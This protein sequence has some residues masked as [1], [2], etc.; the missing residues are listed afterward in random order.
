MKIL[1]IDDEQRIRDSLKRALEEEGY[2][3]KVAEDGPSGLQA[4]EK[5]RFDIIFCDI[6]CPAWTVSK[7]WKS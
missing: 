7:S 5:E 6:K 3:T 1:I 2:V 4:A